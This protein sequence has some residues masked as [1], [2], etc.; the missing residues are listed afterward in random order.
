[1]PRLL[2]LVLVLSL[3][4]FNSGLNSFP[5]PDTNQENCYAR[6]ESTGGTGGGPGGG[7]GGGPSDGGGGPPNGDGTGDRGGEDSGGELPGE[8]GNRRTLQVISCDGT[9]QDASYIT[10]S[11]TFCDNGDETITDL[12]TDL[13]WTQKVYGEG[14]TF[15]DVEAEVSS[16]TL[17]GYNNW[18]IPT[19][20][21]L[22]TLSEFNGKTGRSQEENVPFI[23]SSIFEVRYGTVRFID[24]QLWS[25]NQ[26]TGTSFGRPN[27]GCNFGY[28]SIDGRIKCSLKPYTRDM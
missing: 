22:Y 16:F 18:R 12:N 20:K 25:S 7:D 15:E 19:I 27:Q 5:V 8:S 1:M 6:V 9:G 26:Y 17:A 10:L 14:L 21:E 28:N 4:G 24:G 13:I 2:I 23:D 3:V 11:Q